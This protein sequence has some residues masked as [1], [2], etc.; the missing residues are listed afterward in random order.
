MGSC[1][2]LCHCLGSE[3]KKPC[4][5]GKDVDV[6]SLLRSSCIIDLLPNK[7]N[8]LGLSSYIMFSGAQISLFLR[9]LS[10]NY[11]KLVHIVATQTQNQLLH[12]SW[13]FG[14]Y[15]YFLPVSGYMLLCWIPRISHRRCH[16]LCYSLPLGHYHRKNK[17][18]Y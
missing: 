13:I 2:T 3:P 10:I 9:L 18:A 14:I 6:L 4:L 16:H 15:M 17:S 11:D 5:P 1:L 12:T 8:P 7:V